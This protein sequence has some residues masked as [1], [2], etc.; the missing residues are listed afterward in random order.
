MNGPRYFTSPNSAHMK[1]IPYQKQAQQLTQNK[2]FTLT[3]KL[4]EQ[5]KANAQNSLGRM[6]GMGEGVTRDPKQAVYWYTKA[7]ERGNADAQNSLGR[8][9]D[10]GEG[11]TRNPKQAVFWHTKAAEQGDESAAKALQML[12]K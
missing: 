1:K 5:G 12:G 6:Y 10:N 9:Y 11:V 4:A 3:K 2:A 7:A 8:I